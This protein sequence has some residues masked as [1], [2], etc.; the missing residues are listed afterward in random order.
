[1]HKIL[2]AVTRGLCLGSVRCRR[3]TVVAV[4]AW[5]AMNNPRPKKNNLHIDASI[6]SG[7]LYSTWLL[8]V[9]GTRSVIVC[10]RNSLK[11]IYPR[12]KAQCHVLG[13]T[14]TRGIFHSLVGRDVMEAGDGSQLAAESRP[15][16][17]RLG[18]ARSLPTARY[19]T[20]AIV[21]ISIGGLLPKC[22]KRE[23]WLRFQEQE[24]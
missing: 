24:Q 17:G 6:V 14:C 11:V 19:Y 22:Q 3:W 1:M 15:R 21:I 8:V 16:L 5:T 9:T 18:E 2:T 7:L 10:G 4:T 12:R 13:W 23:S 20:R